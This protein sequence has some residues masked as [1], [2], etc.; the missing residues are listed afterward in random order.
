MGCDAA[1][2]AATEKYLANY[3]EREA[4][5][6]AQL[7]PALP[8]AFGHCLVIPCFDEGEEFIERLAGHPQIGCVLTIVVINQPDRQAESPANLRLFRLLTENHDVI[9]CEN[10]YFARYLGLNLIIVDRFRGAL[11]IS[12]RHG[13]GLARKVGV[14][15]ACRLIQ[16]GC[17]SSDFVFSG[18]ADAHLPDNYFA[19]A[20]SSDA[21]GA[22]VFDFAHM[23]TADNAI[24]TATQQ[25][26]RA[27]KYYRQ[28]LAWANSPYAF[29]T[30]GS[31]FA[32]RAKHYCQARGF[33][34]RAG[35]E[36]FYLLNKIAKL[37]AIEF[38]PHVAIKLESRLSHRIPFGT[39]PAV[40]AIMTLKGEYCYYNP[41]I[42]EHLKLCIAWG[43]HQLPA[44]LLDQNPRHTAG[45]DVVFT[46]PALAQVVKNALIALD[47]A[48]LIKHLTRQCK[49]RQAIRAHFH[50]WF[51]GFRTLKFIHHLQH[52]RFPQVPLSTCLTASATWSKT[53]TPADNAPPGAAGAQWWQT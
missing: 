31:I 10:I 52:A 41:A 26:E 46:S 30:L 29:F 7:A 25:Y 34:K 8:G 20:P 5:I 44:I 11:R 3:A 32:I 9:G 43:N 36:D 18:D 6:I 49:N 16:L 33:P 2:M 21:V 12:H 17:I 4:A 48:C 53:T 39:G 40:A 37:A 14:D 1:P 47:F 13:V 42:F 51:D 19:A 24:S 50:L 28:G 15:I 22:L 27:L 35:G 45:L 38:L 23:T